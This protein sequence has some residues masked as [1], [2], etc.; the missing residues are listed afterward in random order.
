MDN[1]QEMDAL[2]EAFEGE[3]RKA[4]SRVEYGWNMFGDQ[5]VSISTD[6][7]A[8]KMWKAAFES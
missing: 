6:L 1:A 5:T 8:L 2:Q 4:C 3:Q 7:T